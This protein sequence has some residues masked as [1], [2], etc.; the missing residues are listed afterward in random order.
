MAD[1][2]SGLH[3]INSWAD[4]ARGLAPAI[5][6]YIDRKILDA[7]QPPTPTHHHVEFDLPPSLINPSNSIINEPH[8]E[9]VFKITVDQQNTLKAKL[10]GEN[11]NPATKYSTYKILTAHI[12]RCASKARGLA[13]D[14]ATKISIS[15]DGRSR[16][17]P[18]LPPGYFGNVI[19][20][21]TPM[22]RVG[23][24]L[25]EPLI[26]TTKRIHESV[27]QVDDEYVRSAIDYIEKGPDVKTHAF[28]CPN[29]NI[30]TWAT[31]PIY[32]ADFGWGRPIYMRPTSI[33]LE[34]VCMLPSP[35]NDRSL[36]LITRLQHS[37]MKIFEKLLYEYF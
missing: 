24:L 32:D 19:L 23:D 13:D 26:E 6:P 30:G 14:Q 12:W 18:P 22:A 2:L 7:R 33:G 25:S 9:S 4:T 34:G 15:I 16:L 1:G 20:L 8:V 3:F 11:E 37:H 10:W 36:V 35:V 29:L 17:S 31:L 21:A 28:G 27:N 5:K